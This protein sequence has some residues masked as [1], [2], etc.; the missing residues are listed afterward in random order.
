MLNWLQ[1]G[2]LVM[3][4]LVG[5]ACYKYP[6]LTKYVGLEEVIPSYLTVSCVF[7]LTLV[8]FYYAEQESQSVTKLT[9]QL[10]HLHETLN[11]SEM[12]RLKDKVDPEVLASLKRTIRRELSLEM[13]TQQVGCSDRCKL[14]QRL[15]QTDLER[16]KQI[17]SLVMDA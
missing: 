3:S 7:L 12:A 8:V 10:R 17:V 9:S 16:H 15:N 5:F 6:P 4:I 14:T 13:G 11:E 2:I 1:R